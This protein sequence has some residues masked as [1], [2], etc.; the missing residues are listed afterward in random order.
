MSASPECIQCYFVSYKRDAQIPWVISEERK[1]KTF[2]SLE[3]SI[4]FGLNRTD[5][6]SEAGKFLRKFKPQ[7]PYI[8]QLDALLA[9]EAPNEQ[10]LTALRDE[11]NA[12]EWTPEELLAELVEDGAV[13]IVM[14]SVFY[15]ENGF[16]H[17]EVSAAVSLPD[18]I[19][20]M[21]LSGEMVIE[22]IY[23]EKNVQFM[24]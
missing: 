8:Q 23:D 19:E 21:E 16:F 11:I 7:H 14:N 5:G 12:M 13:S 18:G 6:V 24:Y 4:T 17:T 20:P 15:R 22:Q 3:R 2:S 1:K 10:E 9:S